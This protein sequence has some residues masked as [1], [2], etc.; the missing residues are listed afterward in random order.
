MQELKRILSCVRATRRVNPDGSVTLVVRCTKNPD[1]ACRT[2]ASSTAL[3]GEGPTWFA[4]AQQ[5][6]S[7][8]CAQRQG[9]PALEH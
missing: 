5:V 2:F 9:A 3:E 7:H 6:L 8:R 4:H 1:R